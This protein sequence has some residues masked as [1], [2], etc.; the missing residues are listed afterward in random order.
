MSG[1]Q[2]RNWVPTYFLKSQTADRRQGRWVAGQL[3]G[4]SA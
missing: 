3:M 4:R 2:D 1:S